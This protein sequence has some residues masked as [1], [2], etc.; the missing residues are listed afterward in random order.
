MVVKRRHPILGVW[1][2]DPVLSTIAPIGLAT[3][4]GTAL[5][6]DFVVTGHAGSRTLADLLAEGPKLSELSPAR[7][8]IALLP[9]GRVTPELAIEILD[10]LA[11]HWPAMVVRLPGPDPAFATVPVIPLFPGKMAPRPEPS[12]GVWQPVGG[13]ADP[14]GPGPILP[15]LRPGTVRRIFSGQLP[16]RNRWVTAWRPVWEMPWA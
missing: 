16:R 13:G 5:V 1:S 2:P 7:Q 8:G 10:Q 4:V 12:P 11:S 15:R 6:I 14:P 9:A 3:S